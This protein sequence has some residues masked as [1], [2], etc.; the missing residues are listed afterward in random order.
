VIVCSKDDLDEALGA[1]VSSKDAAAQADAR[2]KAE[3]ARTELQEVEAE[4]CAGPLLQ[5]H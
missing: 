4:V 3:R 1:A 5:K 2:A